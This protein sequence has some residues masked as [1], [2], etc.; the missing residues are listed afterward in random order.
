MLV[1]EVEDA[2]VVDK[3]IENRTVS[4]WYKA[5]KNNSKAFRIVDEQKQK[6]QK[7][8]KELQQKQKLQKKP[9]VKPTIKTRGCIQ[10]SVSEMWDKL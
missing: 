6:L 8:V 7:Q 1:G 3:K 10:I 4:Y 5:A 9:I 2:K